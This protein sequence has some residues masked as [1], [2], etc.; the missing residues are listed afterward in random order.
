MTLSRA[1]RVALAIAGVAAPA[2]AQ[3]GYDPERSPFRDLRR[4]TAVALGAGYFGG[5]AGGLGVGATGGPTATA[6][7]EVTLG[8]PTLV[9]VGAT[10]AQLERDVLDPGADSTDR[11]TGPFGTDIVMLDLGLQLRLTGQ[12]SWRRLAPYVGAAL[13]LALEVSGPNDP[14]NY[15]F[16]TKFTV[17]PGAGVRFYPAQRLSV[18]ADVRL[19]FWRLSYPLSYQTAGPDGSRILDPGANTTDWTTHPWTT[20]GVAWTF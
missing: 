19:L 16:G 2:A 1:V 12:K 10:W 3:V 4:G 15:S 5:E 7:F 20:V 13:G 11:R 17:A 18:V 8:G 6:R 14:G 9:S